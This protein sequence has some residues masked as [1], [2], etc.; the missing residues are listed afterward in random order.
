MPDVADAS[1]EVATRELLSQL[2]PDR[3]IAFA[4]TQVFGLTYDEAASVC[5][6]PVGTI[7]SR[8]ARARDDLIAL[9][10]VVSRDVMP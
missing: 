4:L 6:C 9:M 10:D 7:R 5:G 3:R 1:D 8:V 2:E